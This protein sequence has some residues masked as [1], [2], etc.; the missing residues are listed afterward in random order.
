M[1]CTKDT[2][3]AHIGEGVLRIEE[4]RPRI[5]GTSKT[6]AVTVTDD[7]FDKMNDAAFWPRNVYVKRDI[8]NLRR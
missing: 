4:R 6:F 7:A 3:N 2:L 5:A 1:T 8:P